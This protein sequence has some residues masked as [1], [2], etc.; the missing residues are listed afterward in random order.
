MIE[1]TTLASCMWLLQSAKLRLE[2]EHNKLIETFTQRISEED[3]IQTRGVSGSF[4]ELLADIQENQRLINKHTIC[5]N[6]INNYFN[7]I[8]QEAVP[9]MI[10]KGECEV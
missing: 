1:S 8:C 10:T 4:I 5:I 9:V 3:C 6:D 2:E 7:D